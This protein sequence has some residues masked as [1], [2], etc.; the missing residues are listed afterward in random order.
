MGMIILQ[1]NCTSYYIRCNFY[2][3]GIIIP[4]ENGTAVAVFAILFLLTNQIPLTSRR[5]IVDP[6]PPQDTH[7]ALV[8]P[9]TSRPTY[10]ETYSQTSIPRLTIDTTSQ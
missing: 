2:T 3:I 5:W 10:R 6:N 7:R 1:S 9:S 8:S 4:Y